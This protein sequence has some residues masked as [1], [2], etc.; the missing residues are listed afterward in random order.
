MVSRSGVLPVPRQ[1]AQEVG[2]G[3]GVPQVQPQGNSTLMLN[4]HSFF[5]FLILCT[6]IDSFAQPNAPLCCLNYY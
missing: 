6:F 1:A 3:A 4:F 2:R 5:Y